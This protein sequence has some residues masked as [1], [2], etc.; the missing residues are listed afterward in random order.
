MRRILLTLMVALCLML[1][2]LTATTSSAKR[3]DAGLTNFSQRGYWGAL[4]YSSSTG[5]F[6]FAYDYRTQ[7]DAI[8]AA[9][10][11]C[12]ARDCQGVVWF[13]NGCGAFARGRGAWGWGIGNN[14]AEA[15][16]KALAE[17]RKHGGY[18]RVIEWA[19]TTR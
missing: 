11:K 13:H 3:N 17:C 2:T 4:A 10:A 18:C 14:R 7:A 8:N 19:C 15:E 6:G 16:S 12:R 5:R 1:L 9:V